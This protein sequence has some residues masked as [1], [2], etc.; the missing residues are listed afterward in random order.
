MPTVLVIED[1]R[2]LAELVAFHLEK[3]GYSCVIAED[4]SLGLAEA[5]RLRPDLI[6]LDLMLPGMMG[7]EVCR[8]LKG[9]EHTAGIPIIMLTAKGEEIDRVVGFEM[10]ADD[11]VVKPFSTRELM[12]RVRAVLRRSTEQGTKSANISVGGLYIDTEG[13][14]VEVAG[15][16]VTLTSTEFK[17]LMNLAERIGRVQSR[18][19][20][21]QNV[22]GYSYVGDTRTVD[23]HMTRLR[24][25][26]GSAGEMI[27]TVR[28]FGYKLEEG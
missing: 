15:E 12:L 7:T 11:Y 26:L 10:G 19:L 16:E 28:G 14:R 1:E 3:E 21:L 13:H 22:W 23:T 24:T 8:I 5:R 27:K 9:A 25:K 18:E 2:D 20:L 6:L 17:L 4:G